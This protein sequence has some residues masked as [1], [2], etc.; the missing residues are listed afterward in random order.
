MLI[1][2]DEGLTLETP[3]FKFLYGGQFTIFTRLI[4]PL[5]RFASL[6]TQHQSSFRSKQN[7]FTN[8]EWFTSY[9]CPVTHNPPRRTWLNVTI[10]FGLR[11]RSCATKSGVA[12]DICLKA[13][14]FYCTSLT[15][16]VARRGAFTPFRD[17]PHIASR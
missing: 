3:S 15:A 8:N 1:Y 12:L 10:L 4:N 14:A 7:P 2:S 16:T 5:L 13:S 11:K 6:P 17:F 9:L